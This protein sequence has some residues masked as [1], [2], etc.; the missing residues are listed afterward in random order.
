[1]QDKQTREHQKPKADYSSPKLV[2]HGKVRDL[3]RGSLSGVNDPGGSINGAKG[4]P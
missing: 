2:C 3:T 1:M 4:P